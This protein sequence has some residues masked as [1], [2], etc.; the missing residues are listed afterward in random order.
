V[1]VALDLVGVGGLLQRGADGISG[2]GHYFSF[3]G[4]RTGTGASVSPRPLPSAA[5]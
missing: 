1:E 3:Y 2:D 5:R 4:R